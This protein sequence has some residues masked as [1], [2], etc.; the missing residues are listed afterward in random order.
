MKLETELKKLRA[1]GLNVAKL[2]S[3]VLEIGVEST[4]L[5]AGGG[6]VA[7]AGGGM[8]GFAEGRSVF[9]KANETL[10]RTNEERKAAKIQ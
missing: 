5:I 1:A 2:F 8:L 9:D 10:K 7:I 3:G 6:I 4:L